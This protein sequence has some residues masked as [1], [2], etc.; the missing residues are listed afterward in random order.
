MSQDINMEYCNIP[1]SFLFVCFVLVPEYD[2]HVELQLTL[3]TM[4]VW[5]AVREARERKAERARE[6]ERESE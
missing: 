4:R 2:E 5:M 3:N 1:C 6:R